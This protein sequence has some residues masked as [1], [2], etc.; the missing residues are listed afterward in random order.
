MSRTGQVTV[1]DFPQMVSVEHPN[2]Q[3]YFERDV[4][5]ILKYFAMKMKTTLPPE[6][7]NKPK[8]MPS[9]PPSNRI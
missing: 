2:A 6:Q 7:A 8:F 5:G 4:A 9:T 1:I 3:F